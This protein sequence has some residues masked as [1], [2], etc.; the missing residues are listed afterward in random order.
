MGA[1]VKP[2]GLYDLLAPQFP[3]AGAA[4]DVLKA[5]GSQFPD[6]IDKYLSVL[7]VADLHSTSDANSIL[8]TGTVFFPS[9]PGNPPVLQHR[10]P[11]GRI[12]DI[13]DITLQFRLLVPR[14]GS[15][16]IKSVI[17]AMANA[18]Q[19]KPVQDLVNSLGAE[20][21]TP[22]DYPGIA[23]QLE[24]LLSG[25][26]F[27]LGDDWRPGKMGSDFFL[28]I[29]P[30]ATSSDVRIVLPKVLMRYQQGQDFTT[31]P[32]F[33]LASWGDPGYDAPNDFSEG[34]LA[35]MD[36]PLAVKKSLRFGMAID[37]IVVDLS[38]NSTPPEIL[39]N[40]GEDD[41]F[42]GVYIKLLQIY[43][44][45]KDKDAALNFAIRDA[46]VSFGGDFSF[47]AE[48]DLVL[49]TLFGVDVRIYDGK[50]KV[51]FNAGNNDGTPGT[52]TGGNPRFRPRPCFTF[53]S[54]AA[55]HRSTIPSPSHPTAAAHR[56]CGTT[57][58]DRRN[59]VRRRRPRSTEPS[60]SKSPTPPRLRIA[61]RTRSI[62]R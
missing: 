55:S 59:S 46:L 13:Q 41:S 56:N 31:S 33:K 26:Q 23:F 58:C 42:E 24:L 29:D 16:P 57:A 43:Y 17:D 39:D 3:A 14:A 50:N 48:L 6:Y 44:S 45:D 62:S 51:T 12:F 37:E 35:T 18:P 38:E 10:E 15:G 8:Y 2:L 21:S 25:L 28:T 54:P 49:D 40:F 4:V 1:T 5:V 47:E 30:D 27:H 36:P 53:R 52:F 34:E 20:T 61:T 7:A 32:S 11:S 22:T 9:S 60:S 19:L